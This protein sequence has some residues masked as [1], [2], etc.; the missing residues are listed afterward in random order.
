MAIAYFQTQVIGRGRQIT[1]DDDDEWKR[2]RGGGGGQGVNS[3]IGFSRGSSRGRTS[4][5]GGRGRSAIAA[6][7]YRAGEKLRDERT[8]QVHDFTR[9]DKILHCEIMLPAHAP[10]RLSDR[11]T[12][13]NEVEGFEK[14]N[15]AQF[16]R[17]IVLALPHELSGE[18]QVEL[19]RSFVHEQFVDRGMIADIAVHEPGW[20]SDTRNVHAHVMLTMRRVGP[21]GFGLKERAW[22]DRGLQAEWRESW[23]NCVNGAL[24]R[25]G[26]G[27]RID[28]RSRAERISDF[29]GVSEH[30]AVPPD[31]RDAAAYLVAAGSRDLTSSLP[32][33]A[34]Y[35]EQR[36]EVSRAGE[37]MRDLDPGLR[38]DLEEADSFVLRRL[39][40]AQPEASPAPVAANGG[41]EP[42]ELL[43]HFSKMLEDVQSWSDYS[44]IVRWI[45]DDLVD[46]L[47]S[48]ST[49]DLSYE[50]AIE[51]AQQAYAQGL[52]DRCM[53]AE[54]YVV[55]Y[56][57]SDVYATFSREEIVSLLGARREMALEAGAD[58]ETLE[59]LTDLQ[60]GYIL[61]GGARLINWLGNIAAETVA[62]HRELNPERVLEP[63]RSP[64]EP[65]VNEAPVQEPVHDPQ[66]EI[67]VVRKPSPP[68][69]GRGRDDFEPDF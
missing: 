29:K 7:A 1:G 63:E 12:L 52:Y 48:D 62:A 25:D 28:M 20:K 59:F 37:A 53:E 50:Q 27:A 30:K 56:D 16:C 51:M 44:R 5:S 38:D 64:M 46:V 15:D 65:P 10:K 4:G 3:Q 21:E 45:E 66:P 2:R 24:E 55:S 47:G 69:R 35:M 17:E 43:D 19:V 58:A 36:G 39:M 9:R 23:E 13:W 14:R 8:G 18:R 26:I 6:S 67:D 41:L 49:T 32:R 34:W 40:S 33:S 42:S 31:V 61:L 54:P 60:A 68:N 22:N 11:T 57:V